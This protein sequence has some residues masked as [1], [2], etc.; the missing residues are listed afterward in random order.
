L[1]DQAAA[2]SRWRRDL[3]VAHAERGEARRRAGQR[4][5]AA[6]DFRAALDL[7]VALRATA[8]EDGQLQQDE[9]WLRRRLAP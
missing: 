9:A 3:A 6:A 4:S 8:P 1:V 7:I 2:Q 5:A